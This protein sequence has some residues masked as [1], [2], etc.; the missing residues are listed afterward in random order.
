MQ[1]RD[2]PIPMNLQVAFGAGEKLLYAR[3]R[4]MFGGRLRWTITGAAPIAP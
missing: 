4:D 2:E 3:V 1:L